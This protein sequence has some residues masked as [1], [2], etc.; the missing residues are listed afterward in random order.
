MKPIRKYSN[1]TAF[2]KALEDRL[3]TLATKE[4]VNLQRFRREVAFDRFLMRLFSGKE[5]P[6]ILKGGYAMEL[7]IKEARA[8]KDIDLAWREILPKKEG[9]SFNQRVLGLMQDFAALDLN[10]FFVF[11]VGEPV[12]DMDAAPYAGAR[13][14]IEARMDGRLFVNFHID[15]AAG[16]VFIEPL[17]AVEGRDWL[18][19]AGIPKA[20]VK[21]IPKEQHFAEKLHAYTQ[22]RQ[23][24]NSRVRDLVDMVLLIQSD[25]LNKEKLKAAI[26][27]TFHRRDT[28]S[29][30]KALSAPP[31]EWE[32]PFVELARE[33]GLS[34]DLLGAFNTI[35]AFLRDIY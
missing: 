2:R 14:P 1:A 3:Q 16:D 9:M 21:A 15:V 19:F 25:K 17:E 5:T 24:P 12:Q 7:R 18:S 10:D 22:P 35:S 11:M 23:R 28:H 20:R 26:K 34:E 27:A 30:P 31:K 4:G 29:I 6:W 13:F 32:K 8:T 33:C